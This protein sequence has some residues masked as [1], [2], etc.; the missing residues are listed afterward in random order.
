VKV[1]YRQFAGDDV[2]RQFRCYIPEV[3]VRFRD[4]VRPTVQSLSLHRTAADFRY[5]PVTP[6]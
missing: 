2:V 1:L 3:A 4:A 5:A 6:T